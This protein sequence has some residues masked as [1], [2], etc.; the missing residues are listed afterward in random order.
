MRRYVTIS[1]GP[2]AEQAVP[3]VSSSDPQVVDATLNAIRRR[4][5]ARHESD[6]PSPDEVPPEAYIRRDASASQGRGAP[7]PR[8][9]RA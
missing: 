5:Q 3:I 9:R 7:G 8:A 2:R 4:L 6:D 1:A